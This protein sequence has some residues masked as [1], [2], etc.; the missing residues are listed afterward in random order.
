MKEKA[1]RCA[2]SES[3]KS[4]DLIMSPLPMQPSPPIEW[5][6]VMDLLDCLGKDPAETFLRAIKPPRG[7]VHKF[8]L[9]PSK[10]EGYVRDGWGLYFNVGN[11]GTCKAEISSVP[12]FWAE[13]DH[14]PK[15]A[16]INLWQQLGLPE[17]S[18]QIDTAG[19]SIHTYWVLD[20]PIRPDRWT[21]IQK[22]LLDHADADQSV[23]DSSR[24]MRL[25]G[26]LRRDARGRC[27]RTSI[28]TMN[29][30]RYRAE[31][32][33]ACLPPVPSPPKPR[34]PYRP[35]GRKQPQLDRV[36]DALSH[37][38]RRVKG[39]GTY[40]E[41]RNV[42]WALRACLEECGQPDPEAA[43]IQLLEAHSPSRECGWDVAQ[44]VRS[45][46]QQIG[47]GTLFHHAKQYGY[48][49]KRHG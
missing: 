32:V 42:A 1:P 6:Q 19:K 11:G 3:R 44:V 28:V 18:V 12:A 36:L 33:E 37:I 15:S 8:R 26:V 41:M 47:P 4:L 39:G 48:K 43:T 21:P 38:P 27:Q 9:D 16:Q 35:R 13:W 23:K 20:Q 10:A 45:G 22:R 30:N 46:G 2:N 49:P 7:P 24:V 14:I 17:P 29:S 25:P 34:L 5:D 40:G 31:D